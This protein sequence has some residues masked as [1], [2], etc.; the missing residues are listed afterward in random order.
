MRTLLHRQRMR[1]NIM[2][3][4][5]QNGFEGELYTGDGTKNKVV[6]VMSGSN[7]GMRLTK[8]EASFYHKNGI[9]ALALALFKTNQTGKFLDRV[10]VEYVENAIKWLKEQG[11]QKIGI[12]GMS[13]GSEMALLA[14]SMFPELSC[15]IARVPSYFVSEGLSGKGLA[16]EPSG[17][18]CWSYKGKEIPY[19]PYNKRTFDILKMFKEEKELRIIRFNRDKNV[20]PETVIPVEN[21]KAPILLLSSK[22]DEVWPSYE[23][24]ICIEN[25][26]RDKAFSYPVKHIAYEHMSHA[27]ITKIPLGIKF[28]F[29]SERQHPK[30]CKAERIKL[31][32]ELINWVNQ[33]DIKYDEFHA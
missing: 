31:Q 7:G 16:K 1:E 32:K 10:P 13:K 12:D 15:V 26:L 28:V 33:V 29:K 11:Y 21:I 5:K 18:S 9:P 19:A 14:A 3:T 2:P 24:S 22:N 20:T 25:R 4:V 8:Q 6:I 27:M 30:E 23:S 17:T